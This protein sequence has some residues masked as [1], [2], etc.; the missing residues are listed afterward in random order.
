GHLPRHRGGARSAAARGR[1]RRNP[2]GGARAL[3]PA[4]GRARPRGH[5][6]ARPVRSLRAPRRGGAHARP[7]RSPVRR[8]EA[9]MTMRSLPALAL[10]ALL[11]AGCNGAGDP[12]AQGWVEAEM[13]FVGPDD[14]GRVQTLAVREGDKVDQGAPLFSVDD[15]LQQAEVAQISATVVNMQRTM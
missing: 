7:S 8:A 2:G 6:L 10:A 14:P 9:G 12:G 4:A 11:L 13:L 15:D 3:S 1:A 5:R